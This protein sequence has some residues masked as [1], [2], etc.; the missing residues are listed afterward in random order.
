MELRQMTEP[1]ESGVMHIAGEQ[2]KA[3]SGVNESAA[4]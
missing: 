3:N 4:V 2:I 1:G